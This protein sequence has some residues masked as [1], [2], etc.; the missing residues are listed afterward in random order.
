MSRFSSRPTIGLALGGG[1][2]GLAHIGVLRVLEQEHIPI[3]FLAGSSMGAVIGAGYAAGLGTEYLEHEAVRMA[4]RRRLVG[5]LHRSLPRTT[6]GLIEGRE[7]DRYFA[8]RL[9]HKNFAD[10]SIPL[11][12]VAADL[13][14]G[15]QVIIDSGA[16]ATAL[17]ASG[18]LPGVFA[19]ARLNG[20]L[21]VDGAVLNPVPLD[22]VR[23]M[24]AEIVIA[25]DVGAYPDG[26]I[27]DAIHLSL[28]QAPLIVHSLLRIVGLMQMQIVSH[29][30]AHDKPDIL[31]RPNLSSDITLLNG[32]S[33][34]TEC[35]AA[36]EDAMQQAMP[37]L[38]KL[39][40]EHREGQT[41]CGEGEI[42]GERI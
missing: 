21:L 34:V 38:V 26:P 42:K 6:L 25:V 13:E 10:L 35:V 23:R 40:G 36:G 37:A 12:V 11:A 41:H 7:V 32:L 24:G 27:P 22:V 2:R 17:R 15:E 20:R 1:I 19:P 14:T 31:L 16:V 8:E 28:R 30:L 39:L 29:K 3:D 5:L 33:R 9:A 4:D 18:S